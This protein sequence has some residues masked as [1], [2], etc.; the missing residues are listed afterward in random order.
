MQVLTETIHDAPHDPSAALARPKS[1]LVGRDFGLIDAVWGPAQ[2]ERL[3][4]LVDLGEAAWNGMLDDPPDGLHETE[5]IFSTWGMPALGHEELDLLPKLRAVFYAAGTVKEFADPFLERGIPIFSGWAAN[6][7]PVAEYTLSQILFALKQGWLH[8]RHLLA[9]RGPHG[10]R[11]V[12]TT[13]AYGSSVGIISL[14]MIGSTVSELLAPFEIRRLAYDPFVPEESMRE[15]DII[16]ATLQ[17][18]F[19]TADAVTVHTPW[20]KETEG[21]ITG[22]LLASM[23][24]GSTFINTSRGALVREEEMIEVLSARPDLT[25]VLDVTCDEP[26]KPDSSL[27]T[28]PNVVLT[29]HIAGAKGTEMRRLADWMLDECEAWLT[30]NP[31]RYEVTREN[32]ARMA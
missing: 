28:L 19:A 25:A 9:N 5:I 20:L 4:N 31:V 3:G 12:P 30:G 8:Q 29:P 23:K 22:K 7:V 17:E 10:W 6:A 15:R 14:G 2:K 1:L 24:W 16:P 11:G 26:P 13:G 32:I 21:L 27:Y 18:I